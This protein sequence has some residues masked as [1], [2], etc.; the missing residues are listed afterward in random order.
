MANTYSMFSYSFGSNGKKQHKKITNGA[1]FFLIRIHFNSFYFI[2]PE[3]TKCY[4]K[5]ICVDHKKIRKSNWW[6]IFIFIRLVN[7]NNLCFTYIWLL[8]KTKVMLKRKN[9]YIY[10]YLFGCCHIFHK[11]CLFFKTYS[12]IPYFDMRVAWK[13]FH[14]GVPYK[15]SKCLFE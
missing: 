9:K 8:P 2:L 11:Q 3:F 12:V 10:T 7:L 14:P 5:Q 4:P 1:R 6:A 13:Y 15:V